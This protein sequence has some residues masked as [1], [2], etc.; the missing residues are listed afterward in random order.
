[1]RA[2]YRKLSIRTVSEEGVP[3]SVVQFVSRHI[4]SLEQLEILLF[5]H[6]EG[7]RPRTVAEIFKRIQ[8]SQASVQ[9]RLKKLQTAGLVASDEKG[10]RYQSGNPDT[11]ACVAALAENYKLRRV[12][13]IEAIYAPKPDAAQSFADAFRLRRKD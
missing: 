10:Y 5:L 6:G 13:I 4:E 9:D 2:R 8:S 3:E 11:D 12:R 7:S 1:M